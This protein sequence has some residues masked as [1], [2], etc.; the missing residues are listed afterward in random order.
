MQ[1]PGTER[2][3]GGTDFKWGGRAP[4]APPLATAL[5]QWQQG[6]NIALLQGCSKKV[7]EDLVFW[8][9]Q[10]YRIWAQDP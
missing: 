8:Q 1:Q 3:M 4:L 10:S 6:N 9:L 7:F 2:K 5:H